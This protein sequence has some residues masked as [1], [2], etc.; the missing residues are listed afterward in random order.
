MSE[1][2]QASRKGLL[3][4]L[5]W[6]QEQRVPW[7]EELGRQQGKTASPDF[8]PDL[9]RKNV[10]NRAVLR[11]QAQVAEE[12]PIA[13]NIVTN[14]SV[15]TFDDWFE[16]VDKDGN[17]HPINEEVQKQFRFLDAQFIYTQC[18]I[19]MRKFGWCWQQVG[20]E[21]IDDGAD[22]AG[23]RVANLDYFS[24][25]EMIVVETDDMN[26]PKT[27]RLNIEGVNEV[28]QETF[29]VSDF[30]L[31]NSDP[32]GRS[33]KGFPACNGAWDALTELRLVINAVTWY[34][35][36][37]GMG[38]WIIEL[39]KSVSDA[40]A[41][42]IQTMIQKLNSR[43]VAMVNKDKVDDIN[44]K[45]APISAASFVEI[46]N[47][48]LGRVAAATSIPADVFTGQSAGKIMGSDVNLK[49]L[50]Q[51]LNGIQTGAARPIRKNI[52]EMGF[53]DVTPEY[54]FKWNVKFVPDAE[55]EAKISF[56]KT[57]ELGIR[58]STGLFTKNE[59]REF[60][61]FSPLAEGGEELSTTVN[62]QM[63]GAEPSDRATERENTQN[64]TK[65]HV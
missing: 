27:L 47:V 38:A 51:V 44:F 53:K 22:T 9:I 26:R 49:S 42:K 64:I 7:A 5:G 6:R 45:G 1:P 60:I 14:L 12:D 57:E 4:R 56:L 63:Q 24:P 13:R 23:R 17:T 29:P 35:M 52:D 54:F 10:T 2:H 11:H 33:W 37:I 18:L 41:A 58:A 25:E 43:T 31:W 46:F 3:A 61:G 40:E 39:K 65:E 15:N 50:Y 36:K 59:L 34:I 48:L 16:L 19:T 30:V 8:V 20:K 62:I 55:Q 32:I 21:K 28:D